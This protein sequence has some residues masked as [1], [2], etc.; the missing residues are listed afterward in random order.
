LKF[1]H[2][3][4]FSESDFRRI[5]GWGSAIAGAI[6]AIAFFNAWNPVGWVAVGVGLVFTVFSLFSDN[7][8][9]KLKEAKS[10]QRQVLLDDIEESKK[11]KG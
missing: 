6:S 11:N 10:E 2:R 3:K 1:H 8:A 9:K 5:N 4:S 7:R